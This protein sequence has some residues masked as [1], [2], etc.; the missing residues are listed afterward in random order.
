VLCCVVLCCVVLCCVVLCCVVLCCVVLCCVCVYVFSV[1]M[2]L[3]LR[4]VRA[5][6]C[7]CA[8][9]AASA[10]ILRCKSLPVRVSG[11][12]VTAFPVPLVPRLPPSSGM[13]APTPSPMLASGRCRG[14]LTRV[15]AHVRGRWRVAVPVSLP[16]SPAPTPLQAPH[17]FHLTAVVTAWRSLLPLRALMWPRPCL[18]WCQLLPGSRSRHHRCCVSRWWFRRRRRC[19]Y[20]LR[21]L[22]Q[23][24]H[25]RPYRTSAG[26][27]S[28][29]WPA[30]P[31][32]TAAQALTWGQGWPQEWPTWGPFLAGCTCPATTPLRWL[33][34]T[35]ACR[36][37]R[38]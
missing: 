35:W 6:V 20:R 31:S 25:R 34:F 2:Y 3:C 14:R 30:P 15:L 10:V 18:V 17:P 19:R 12:C 7:A 32:S 38:R 13:S 1:S 8:G 26:I 5:C 22:V 21:C 37:V 29:L 33:C 4:P 11:P 28:R 9:L 24:Q 27:L 36:P 23:Y 16:V